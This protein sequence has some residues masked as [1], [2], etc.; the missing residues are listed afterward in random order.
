MPSKKVAKKSTQEMEPLA[1]HKVLHDDI[2]FEGEVF[3]RGAELVLVDGEGDALVKR[4]KLE[5]TKYID[6][7]HLADVEFLKAVRQ[8]TEDGDDADE[9]GTHAKAS[10]AAMSVIEGLD[11]EQ[12]EDAAVADRENGPAA[13]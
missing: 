13:E 10:A 7:E 2:E 8:R 11:L 12:L 4:G 3:I 9:A 1:V 6:S 5:L